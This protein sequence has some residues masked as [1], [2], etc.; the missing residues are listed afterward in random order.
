MAV[1]QSITRIPSTFSDLANVVFETILSV[2][3]RAPRIDFVT[4]QYPTLSIKNL[5]RDRRSLGGQIIT[6]ISRPSQ[7]CPRQWKNFVSVG[8]NKVALFEFFMSEL[9]RQSYR[10]T[11]EGIDL[12]VS[13]GSMCHKIS[14]EN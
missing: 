2:S 13:H 11:L 9:S 7:S 1:I 3:K 12:F 4:G 14:V 5:K 6:I 8:R 10:F